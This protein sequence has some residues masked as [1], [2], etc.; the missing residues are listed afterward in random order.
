M[1]GTLACEQVSTDDTLAGEHVSTQGTLAREH[2]LITQGTRGEM[3]R[4]I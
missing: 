2:V 1:Q 3:W 4:H